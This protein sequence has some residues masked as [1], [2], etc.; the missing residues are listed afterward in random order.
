VAVGYI[1]LDSG[2][3]I[4]SGANGTNEITRSRTTCRARCERIFAS[5]RRAD[6][7]AAT[8][9]QSGTHNNRNAFAQLANTLTGVEA[10]DWGGDQGNLRRSSQQ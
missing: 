8:T 3:G 10:G 6:A 7:V 2:G 5:R 1:S 9:P 4:P